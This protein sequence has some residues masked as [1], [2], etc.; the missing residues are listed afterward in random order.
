M[1]GTKFDA[2]FFD[3]G[4]TLFKMGESATPPLDPTASQ[5]R[6]VRARRV[7]AALAALGHQV[8]DASVRLA[9]TTVESALAADLRR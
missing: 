4:G 3:S 9:L 1:T 5:V 6:A 8:D 2:I 7:T